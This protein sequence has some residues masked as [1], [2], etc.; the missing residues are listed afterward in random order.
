[1]IYVDTIRHYPSC[2]LPYK[3]WC[4]LA[5][6]G[7][8]EE[9]H[10]FAGRIGLQRTWFQPSKSGQFPHYDLV[11]SKREQAI[12]SGAIPVDPVELL[13]LC[14]PDAWKVVTAGSE[15]EKAV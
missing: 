10:A 9:L 11:P 6:D 13:R 14:Y 1:M 12:Q 5:T 7:D 3:H 8:L 15:R 2:K 4:H